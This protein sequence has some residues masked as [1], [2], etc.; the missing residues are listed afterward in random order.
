[1]HIDIFFPVSIFHSLNKTII[2]ANPK[3]KVMSN[4]RPQL[5]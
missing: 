4:G 5:K 2:F 1:M 3:E